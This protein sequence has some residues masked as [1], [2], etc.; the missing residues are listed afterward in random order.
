MSKKESGRPQALGGEPRAFFVQKLLVAE[1]RLNF[2]GF[3]RVPVLKPLAGFLRPR[4]FFVAC[5]PRLIFGTPEHG[6]ISV[7]GA[8]L[9]VCSSSA[10]SS[11]AMT[12]ARTRRKS[13]R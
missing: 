4:A 10:K 8:V 1:D 7:S 12:I 11:Q 13:V 6:M 2:R 9:A 3:E 5:L